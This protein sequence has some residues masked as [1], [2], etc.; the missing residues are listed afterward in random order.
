MGGATQ[1]ANCQSVS[2]WPVLCQYIR[3]G[4]SLLGIIKAFD[5]GGSM[6][7]MED[8]TACHQCI[9]EDELEMQAEFQMA[10]ADHPSG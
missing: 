6:H 8:E 1:Q 5:G 9:Q 7:Q 2:D 10:R 4:A 3:P